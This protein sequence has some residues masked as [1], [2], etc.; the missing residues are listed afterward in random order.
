[1]SIHFLSP[2]AIIFLLLPLLLAQVS[3]R[4]LLAKRFIASDLSPYITRPLSQRRYL[5]PALLLAWLCFIF[6]LMQPRIYGWPKSASVAPT[7]YIDI[8]T[9]VDISPS[10]TASDMQPS[11]LKRAINEWLRLEQQLPA[12]RI[13]LIAYSAEAYP[14]LPLSTDHSSMRHYIK[15]LGSQLTRRHGSNLTQALE[16]ARTLLSDSPVSG[17]AIL[18][19][20]DGEV[21]AS[22]VVE[23][24]VAQL[25]ADHIPLNILALGSDSGAP[26]SDGR[27]HFLRDDNGALHVS[28]PRFNWLQTLARRS[29]GAM[30][31]IGQDEDDAVM[32]VFSRLQGQRLPQE[33]DDGYPLTPW[34]IAASVIVFLLSSIPFRHD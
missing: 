22:D 17:R 10:M 5:F 27:G 20:T 18:L 11:R 8:V 31:V 6:A 15:T 1:M 12:S 16:L 7:T 2:L 3:K 13:A 33:R 14:L 4:R 26:I 25:A 19:L 28:R 30:T 23:K 24:T 32:A 9:V 29:S 34:L 21:F